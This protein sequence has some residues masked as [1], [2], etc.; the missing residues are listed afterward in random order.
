MYK[1]TEEGVQRLGDGAF[2]PSDPRNKDW[3]EYQE[4]LK[5]GN[6]PEPLETPQEREIRLK[7]EAV[8]EARQFLQETDWKVLRYLEDKAVGRTPWISEED[9]GALVTER[10]QKR[11]ILSDDQ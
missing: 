10:E 6:I 1:L 7:A 5:E 11:Q 9:F 2:I 3:R 4:W 8:A